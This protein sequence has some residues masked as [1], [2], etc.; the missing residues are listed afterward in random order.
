MS[1]ITKFW[2]IGPHANL[3]V[4]STFHDFV[5][6]V[7]GLIIEETLLGNPGFYNADYYFKDAGVIGELKE[8]ETEFLNSDGPK[9]KLEKLTER[10]IKEIPNF[11]PELLVG[12]GE[13]PAWFKKEFIRLARPAI[14]RILKKANRQIRET[15]Q[16]LNAP[17]AQGILFFVNDGFTGLAPNLVFALACDALTNSYSS[18]DCFIYISLNRYIE[19]QGSNEPKLVWAPS[20]SDR[21]DEK[22]VEFVDALGRSWFDCLETKIG[23]PTSR[24]ETQDRDILRGSKSIVLPGES[25]S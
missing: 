10:L 16:H 4:E 12:S 3:S 21:S 17:S 13:Y 1:E 18:I 20:Y 9:K 14:T 11:K 22:L 23:K 15:K 7:G 5:R 25:R 6:G 19:I 2:D 8:I 24:T